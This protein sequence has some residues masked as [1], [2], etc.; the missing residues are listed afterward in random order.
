[1]NVIEQVPFSAA[2]RLALVVDGREIPLSQVGPGFGVLREVEDLPVGKNATLIVSV[3]GRESRWGVV[4]I[5]GTVPFELDFNYE[6]TQYP[7]RTE[8]IH[9]RLRMD[10]V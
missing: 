3:D 2:V 5:N 10:V 4:L 6:I 1:M 8:P 9:P 7:L